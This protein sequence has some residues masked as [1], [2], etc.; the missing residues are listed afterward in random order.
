MKNKNR[1]NN[2]YMNKK[3]IDY[4]R[5]NKTKQ[6]KFFSSNSRKLNNK[7]YLQIQRD[8]LIK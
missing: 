3:N 4:Q 6:P 5:N 1:L 8:L 2:I 7:K